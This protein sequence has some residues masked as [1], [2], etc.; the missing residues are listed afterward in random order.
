[1]A[2]RDGSQSATPDP[3]GPTETEPGIRRVAART[4]A[5]AT[6]A[7]R[8]GLSLKDIWGGA[9]ALTLRDVSACC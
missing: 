2:E 8:L 7:Y 6:H 9:A 3:A 4:N 1:M 5:D